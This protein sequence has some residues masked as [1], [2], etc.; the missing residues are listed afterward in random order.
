MAIKALITSFVKGYVHTRRQAAGHRYTCSC[1]LTM[2]KNKLNLKSRKGGAERND[3]FHVE[4][5]Q[6]MLYNGDEKPVCSRRDQ[7]NTYFTG[8]EYLGQNHQTIAAWFEALLESFMAAFF[9]LIFIRPPAELFLLKYFQGGAGG[10]GICCFGIGLDGILKGSSP[11]FRE[12]D[13]M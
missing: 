11:Y 6:K 13:G 1:L 3:H 4:M 7:F 12:N 8:W 5:T 9:S 10:D 2:D